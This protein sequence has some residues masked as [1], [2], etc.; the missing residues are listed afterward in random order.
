MRLSKMWLFWGMT[1]LAVM[2]PLL[3][4]NLFELRS[5]DTTLNT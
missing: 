3:L 5:T 2:T 4:Q 1:Y